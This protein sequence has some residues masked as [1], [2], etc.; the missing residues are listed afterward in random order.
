MYSTTYIMIINAPRCIYAKTTGL[1]HILTTFLKPASSK[2]LNSIIW[3][4]LTHNIMII[5]YSIDSIG[6]STYLITS[7]LTLIFTFTFFIFS[8]NYFMFDLYKSFSSENLY[9]NINTEINTKN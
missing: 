3:K 7:L 2:V 9:S 8:F 4:T 1:P 5:P 6:Y